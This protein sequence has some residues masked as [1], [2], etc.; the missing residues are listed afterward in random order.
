MQPIFIAATNMTPEVD[1]R[2]AEAYLLIRGESYPE[3][4]ISFYAPILE[5]LRAYVHDHKAQQLN[6][7]ILI[8]YYNSASAKAFHRLMGLFNDAC[9]GGCKTSVT[10]QHDEEDEMMLELGNDLKDEFSDINFKVEAC[11]PA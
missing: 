2:P 3:N 8:T 7:D 1:F 4:V 9:K 11:R 5:A 10:W 6:V